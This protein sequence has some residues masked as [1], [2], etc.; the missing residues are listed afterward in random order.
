M[1]AK[2]QRHVFQLRNGARLIIKCQ[3]HRLGKVV[4]KA[5]QKEIVRRLP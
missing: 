4:P 3:P 1:F 5:A 2:S